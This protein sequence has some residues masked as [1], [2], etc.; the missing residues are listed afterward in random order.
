M[1]YP[2]YLLV[3]GPE[4]TVV[5]PPSLPFGV[6]FGHVL[7]GGQ[8][9]DQSGATLVRRATLLG[10]LQVPLELFHAD[11]LQHAFRKVQVKPATGPGDT[12]YGGKKQKTAVGQIILLFG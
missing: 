4:K 3:S 1:R 5:Y 6:V 12:I 7:Y 10:Q 2:V 8:G 9:F 11:A